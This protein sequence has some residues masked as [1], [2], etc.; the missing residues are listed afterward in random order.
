M[1]LL[2]SVI[3]TP[4]LSFNALIEGG[5]VDLDTVLGVSSTIA[6]MGVLPKMDSAGAFYTQAVC[7]WPSLKVID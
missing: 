7:A 2:K 3:L 4:G 5:S 1:V 6:T